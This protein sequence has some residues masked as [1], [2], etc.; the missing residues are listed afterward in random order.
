VK[1][2]SLTSDL[3]S[4]RL[5]LQQNPAGLDAVALRERNK[6]EALA[7]LDQKL[8]SRAWRKA[9]CVEHEAGEEE[10]RQAAAVLPSLPVLDKIMRYETKLERQLYR[11]LAQ[12]ERIQRMRRGE[13][14]PAPLTVEVSE[15][16]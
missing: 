3:E 5:R 15:R 2:N 10:A 6:Q 11:A 7:H 9:D 12:L 8:R 1:P 13:L 16:P 14:V 4:L